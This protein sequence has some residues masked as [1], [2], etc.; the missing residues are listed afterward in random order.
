MASNGWHIA[1]TLVTIGS[2]LCFQICNCFPNI[3][4]D[5]PG[6]QGINQLVFG[7]VF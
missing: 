6:W 4:C 3:L 7:K 2:A 1:Q 5:F